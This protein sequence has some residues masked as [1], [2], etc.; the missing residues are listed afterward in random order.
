MIRGALV[1]ALLASNLAL[2]GIPVFLGGI[3][4]LLAGGG[5]RRR[6]VILAMARLGECWVACNN[7]IC[8]AFLPTRWSVEGVDGARNDGH[9]LVLSNHVSWTDIFVLFRAFH[10]RTALLRFFLK[11]ELIWMPLVGQASW[12]LEFPFVKRYSPEYLARHPEKRGHDLRV[13]QRACQRYRD[14]PVAIVNFAEGTRFSRDKQ[15]EQDS[16]YRNLL[17]PRIGG[18][19]FVLASLG[20][21]LDALFDVAIAYPPRQEVTFWDFVC[22]RVPEVRVLARRLE[23]PV[24]FF[25]DAITEPG[26]TRDAFKGW[27]ETIWREKDELLSRRILSP[28]VAPEAQR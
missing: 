27:I 15:E 1:L 16:P 13:T 24:E 17:R 25:D 21:Q 19:A 2:W 23:I 20:N 28:Q 5:R 22:G 7:W 6:L 10:R 11:A 8:D 14:V 12:A 3:V 9:Y 26:P 18:I 4:R